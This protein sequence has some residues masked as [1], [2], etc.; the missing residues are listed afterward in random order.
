LYVTERFLQR[1]YPSP[2]AHQVAASN[3]D[4]SIDPQVVRERRRRISSSNSGG[5]L[6]LGFLGSLS[7]RYKGLHIL[8]RALASVQ[9]TYGQDAVVLEVAGSGDQERW[10]VTAKRLGVQELV[11]FIGVLPG[12]EQVLAWLDSIDALVHPS[13]TEGLPRAV[14]EGMSRAL[15]VLGSSAGGIPE[16]LPEQCLHRPG[17]WRKLADQIGRLSRDAKLRL[18]LGLAN[19]DR[20]QAFDRERLAARRREF[21]AHALRESAG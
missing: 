20:A 3:V 7:V 6:R 8:L 11:R 13:L 2:T 4:I 19:L 1:R 9:S 14:V 15:P 5:P 21:Y 17:D 12:G 18:E 16:L 10:R